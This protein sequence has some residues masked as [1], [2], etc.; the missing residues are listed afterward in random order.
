MRK[1]PQNKGD[2]LDQLEERCYRTKKHLVS[3][4]DFCSSVPSGYLQLTLDNI[5]NKLSNMFLPAYIK[6]YLY[7]EQNDTVLLRSTFN[8]SP[9]KDEMLRNLQTGSPDHQKGI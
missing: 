1:K 4:K 9:L 8:T 7:D 2:R 3:L 6:L 5:V